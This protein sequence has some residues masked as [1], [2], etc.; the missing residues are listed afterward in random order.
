MSKLFNEMGDFNEIRKEIN[1]WTLKPISKD[2]ASPMEVVELNSGYAVEQFQWESYYNALAMTKDKELQKLFARI[3]FQE[4][5][6]LSKLGSV[7]DPN[8]TPMESSLALQM[9]A[10][11]GLSEAAQLE[12]NGI[13]RGTFDYILLDHLTHMKMLSDNASSMGTK[14]GV[15]EMIMVSLGAGTAAKTKAKAENITKGSMQIREGRPIDQQFIPMDEIFKQPLNKDTVDIS[16]FVNAH[17]LLANE[18]QLRNEYQMFR[19]MIPSDD[20]RRLLNLTTAVENI[21]IT[22]LES[23]MDP[24]TS[25]IEYVMIN[26]LME[27]KTHRQGM[28][29]ARSESARS[30]HEYALNEDEQ[31]LDWLRDAYSSYGS[32]AK[33]K[34]TDKLFAQPKMSTSEY[35]NRVAA[36]A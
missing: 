32:P 17:T 30:A 20:V 23:L 8:M 26:E 28:Q 15:F 16:S 25:P 22:M 7:A 34:A 36:T 12:T 24:T 2:Q 21:H 1:N 14:G 31:H 13:L 35:I 10:I 33:F 29:F 11:Q 19:K 18:A 4:E 27:I 6:H 3:S 5:E 9:T